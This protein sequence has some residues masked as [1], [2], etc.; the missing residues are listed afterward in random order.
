MRIYLIRHG[1][2]V[3]NTG[4]NEALKLAD[5]RVVLTDK[6]REQARASA[7]FLREQLYYYGGL[8]SIADRARVW[9]SPYDR[10]RETMNIFN[11]VLR[12]DTCVDIREDINLTEQQFGIFDSVPKEKWEELFP[13]EYRAWSMF[14]EQRGKFW[15][16]PPMGE[17]P[18]DVAVRMKN[19]IGTIQ[20][21]YEK[22]HIDTLFIFTHGTALRTFVMQYLHKSVDWYESE[23]NPGNCWIRMIDGKNDLGYI[24]TGA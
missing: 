2:S 16:R 4:E 15:A 13:A 24:Y 17:S 19:F 10:A 12:F 23:R 22:H 6:G 21:D 14:K 1:E 8:T 5:N 18:F 7:E 3:A 9:Y 11:S 20:R